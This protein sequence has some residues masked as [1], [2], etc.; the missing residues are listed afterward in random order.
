MAEKK[1]VKK[2]KQYKPGR[3]CPKCNSHMA[4]HAD[5][6]TCGKCGYTEF[7]AQHKG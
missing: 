2:F 3:M 7:K 1:E 6:F 4:E 5:R